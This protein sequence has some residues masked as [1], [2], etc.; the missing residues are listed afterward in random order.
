MSFKTHLKTQITRIDRALE[1]VVP[2]SSKHFGRIHEAMRYSVFPGGKR[3]RPVLVL[4]AC[5]LMGGNPEQALPAACAVELIHSYSLIHDDLPCM[6]NDIERRGKPT[7][8]IRF[9]EDI[10]LLAGDGLLTLAFEI[11]AKSSRRNTSGQDAP[12]RLEAV[13]LLAAASGTFGMIGGQVLDIQS[14]TQEPDIAA[15]EFINVHKTGALIAVCVEM[16]CV[17]GKNSP[18][19]RR[20][21][22]HF[23]HTVGLLFQ[24]VDDIIDNQGV[25][26]VMGVK[27]ATV[28]AC[29]LLVKGKD[30]LKPF[31]DKGLFLS[32]LTDYIFQQIKP[33]ISRS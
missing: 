23:G 21:L 7:C 1:R 18:R 17:F 9:G 32:Q 5:R 31:G 22:S 6:D 2:R 19:H 14:Q 11:L 3:F 26:R 29:N 25:V 33:P 30:C 24:I 4:E 12:R 28:R 10:A 13:R 16:G 15:I 20:L 27:Q 8:H